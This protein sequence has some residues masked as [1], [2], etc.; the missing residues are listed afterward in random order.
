MG[1]GKEGCTG[2]QSRPC[3]LF[4]RFRFPFQPL[5]TKQGT[6]CIPRLLLS[7]PTRVIVALSRTQMEL[8]VNLQVEALHLR[9][10]ATHVA[11]C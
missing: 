6:L 7:P 5:F 4:F 1:S 9:S 11:L 3:F 8:P 2:T 10:V